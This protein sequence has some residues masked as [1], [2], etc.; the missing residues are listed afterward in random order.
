VPPEI[1]PEPTPEEREALLLAL[2][3]LGGAP[4]QPSDWW[5]AGIREAVAEEEGE[6]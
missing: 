1:S 3:A 2:A 6:G 5:K 4:G